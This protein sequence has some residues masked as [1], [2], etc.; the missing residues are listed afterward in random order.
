V[1]TSRRSRQ[2]SG[3]AGSGVLASRAGMTRWPRLLRATTLQERL[4]PSTMSFARCRSRTSIPC[5][6]GSRAADF[7]KPALGDGV[8]RDEEAWDD[9][10]GVDHGHARSVPS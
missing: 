9:H 7:V 5:Q 6:P 1:S 8:S 10:V 4:M 3:A 2:V